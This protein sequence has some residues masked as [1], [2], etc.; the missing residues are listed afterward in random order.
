LAGWPDRAPSKSTRWITLAPRAEKR[1][2][3]RSGRS[4]GAP[5][6]A[7]APGQ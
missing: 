6:P 2:A 1:S 7:A 3:M 4:V 5:T